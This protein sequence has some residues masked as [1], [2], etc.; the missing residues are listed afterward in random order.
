MYNYIHVRN[1]EYGTHLHMY[2][3]IPYIC[4]YVYLYFVFLLVITCPYPPAVINGQFKLN[5]ITVGSVASYRCILGY[6]L[7][8]VDS[9]T[10]SPNGKWS[11]AAPTCKRKCIQIYICMYIYIHAYTHVC[12]CIHTCIHALTC[13]H[14]YT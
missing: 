6:V 12:T 3:C 9:L 8:G 13:I 4:I 5:D 11:P 10:C 14:I 2:I 1:Y 7:N